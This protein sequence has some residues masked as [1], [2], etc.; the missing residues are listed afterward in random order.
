MWKGIKVVEIDHSLCTSNLS[1]M[2]R[3]RFSRFLLP[4]CGTVIQHASSLRFD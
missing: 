3:K 2:L 4:G 1:K